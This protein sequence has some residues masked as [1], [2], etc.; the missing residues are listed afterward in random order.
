LIEGDNI[1]PIYLPIFTPE[2]H[3]QV[4]INTPVICRG[5][6]KARFNPIYKYTYY[7]HFIAEVSK[8]AMCWHVPKQIF[9]LM[10]P[11]NPQLAQQEIQHIINGSSSS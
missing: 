10:P 7:H 3:T 8:T 9:K 11:P 5:D 6:I 2:L 1:C 4:I